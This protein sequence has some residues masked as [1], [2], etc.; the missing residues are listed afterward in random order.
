[1]EHERLAGALR[2]RELLR[3]GV[4]CIRRVH[5]EVVCPGALFRGA[6]AGSGTPTARD[7]AR[8]IDAGLTEDMTLSVAIGVMAHSGEAELPV[9][10]SAGTVAGMLRAA[11]VVSWMAVRLGYAR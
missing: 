3:D 5:R 1:M 7:L 10:S 4:I 9:L 11:D 2:A 6:P 8:P